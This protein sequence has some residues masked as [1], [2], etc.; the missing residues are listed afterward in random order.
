MSE[1]IEF[2]VGADEGG[3][4]VGD[5]LRKHSVSRRLC[6]LQKRVPDGISLN[7]TRIRTVDRVC[8][9]DIV[10]LKMSDEHFLEPNNGLYVP[11]V[12][13]DSG[14]VVFDKPT[15][16]P[17]HPSINH[18]H[19]TLGNFFSAKY[20]ELSFR[21]INRLDKDTSGLC[22]IAKN[23]HSAALL[24]GTLNKV[25]YAAVCGEIR[26]G[27]TISA[28]IGRAGDSIIRREVRA[29]GQ[30]AITDYTALNFNGKYTLL[31]ITL[32]TGRTHQIRVHFAYIGHP[33]AGDDFYG[34]DDTDIKYQAL[35]CGELEFTSPAT[36]ERIALSSPLRA[37]IAALF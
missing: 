19:D 16:M 3:M 5:F 29:D 7:G 30:T 13:E 37:D 11:V 35:H 17:V 1:R 26:G 9:G 33:L 8:E 27:G 25:Y 15:D 18:T 24:Q 36:N 14:T 6:T 22:A 31:R 12:Y 23:A 32:R 34:G 28:P 10:A 21:P 2:T 20:P 4:T